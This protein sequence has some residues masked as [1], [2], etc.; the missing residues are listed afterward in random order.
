ME[1]SVNPDST[2]AEHLYP[3]ITPVTPLCSQSNREYNME[4]QLKSNIFYRSNVSPI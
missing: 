3:F 1:F 4:I 2:T